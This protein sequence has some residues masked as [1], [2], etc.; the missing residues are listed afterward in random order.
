[1]AAELDIPP[2]NVIVLLNL[3]DDRSNIKLSASIVYGCLFV[4]AF[5]V[6]IEIFSLTCIMETSSLPVKGGKC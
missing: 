1:M 6:P 4:L 2:P 3:Y 5:F